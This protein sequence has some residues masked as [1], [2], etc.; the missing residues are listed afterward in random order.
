MVV[1]NGGVLSDV[2]NGFNELKLKRGAGE[3]WESSISK[4][5]KK[6]VTQADTKP[7]ISVYADNLRKIKAKMRRSTRR[8]TKSEKEKTPVEAM[9]C[10]NEMEEAAN[11]FLVEDGMVF[12]ASRGRKVKGLTAGAGG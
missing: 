10:E 9:M 3:D 1:Y 11:D 6:G 7:V 8:K 4:R 5:R 2:I 12:K